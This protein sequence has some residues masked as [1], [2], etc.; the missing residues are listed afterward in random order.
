MDFKQLEAYIAVVQ[1]GNFTQAAEKLGISQPTV[2]LQ[3]QKLEA[4]VGAQLLNRSKRKPV[5]TE[6]G[7]EIY[8]QAT[9]ILNT[10]KEIFRIA[11][12]DSSH[13]LKIGTSTVPS[14]YLLPDILTRYTNSH[15]D[16]T[17]SI[18]Q[19]DSDQVLS[20][21]ISNRFQLGFTGMHCS[22]RGFFCIELCEDPMVLITPCTDEYRNLQMS[23]ALLA[24]LF[25]EKPVIMREKGSGG[26]L[27]SSNY[28]SAIGINDY[29]MHVSVRTNDM[30]AVK[31]LVA[32]GAG[33]SMVS[34]KSCAIMQAAGKLFSYPLPGNA[35]MRRFYLV[36]RKNAQSSAA[37]DFVRFVM[38]W[39]H[40]N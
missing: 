40:I 20:G 14:A 18:D 17:F 10:E 28:L 5:P 27:D 21:I 9:S 8:S 4:E 2:S 22:E 15:P 33:I 31:R 23:P 6:K 39:F 24:S 3:V 30:E 37:R 19:S 38:D 26:E 7:L 36:G 16:V 13:L 32:A 29:D 25:R 12:E 1:T 34:A 11:R 35:G